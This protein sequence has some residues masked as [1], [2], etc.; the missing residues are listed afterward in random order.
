M[1]VVSVFAHER[2]VRDNRLDAKVALFG[3]HLAAV[4]EDVFTLIAD[5]HH[6]HAEFA[7]TPERDYFDRFSCSG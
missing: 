6:V 2:E 3:E 4:D 5:G 7:E 1:D